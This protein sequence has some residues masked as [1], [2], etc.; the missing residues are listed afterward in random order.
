MWS[1]SGEMISHLGDIIVTEINLP[2]EYIFIM[3]K[4]YVHQRV[5][6]RDD[7]ANHACQEL[8]SF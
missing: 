8:Q 1:F 6:A 3:A 4:I 2:D 7:Y 5:G